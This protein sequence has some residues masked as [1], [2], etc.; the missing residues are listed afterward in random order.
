MHVSAYAV[1]MAT[2]QIRDVPPELSRRLK[3]RAAA[4]G[5]SLSQYALAQLERSV[6]RPTIDELWQRI[7]AETTARRES[8][9]AAEILRSERDARP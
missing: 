3:A 1:A 5:Q 7:E 6:A 9:G 2:L 8:Y 4:S